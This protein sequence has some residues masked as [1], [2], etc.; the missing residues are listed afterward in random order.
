MNRTFRILLRKELLDIVRDKRMLAMMLM[1]PLVLY[2]ALF[3][4]TGTVMAAGK[5]RL[6]LQEL[7]VAVASDDAQAFLDLRPV[8]KHTTYARMTRA[9]GE[10]GLREKKIFAI[11]DAQP[12]SFAAVKAQAQGVVTIVYTKRQDRSV[13]ARDRV[14]AVIDDV[15]KG[16]LIARLEE[17]NLPATFSEPVK[18]KETDLDFEQNLGPYIASRLLPIMLLLMLF[19]GALY[20]AVDLTAGEKERG[21]LETL[22]VAPVQPLDVMK[23]KFVAV[24]A[25]SIIASVANLGAMGFAFASGVDLGAGKVTVSFSVPQILVMLSCLL[26]AAV[27]AAGI[28]LAIASLA[29]SFKEGQAMMTPVM[30]AALVPGMLAVMPGVELSAWTAC[31]PL[32]NVALLIKAVILQAAQ[33]VHVVITFVSVGLCA[34]GTLKL[35]ANAFHSEALRFGAVRSVKELFFKQ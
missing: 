27:L 24:A 6:A 14:R 12:G 3:V 2:P 11:V 15:S 8:P 26:P 16:T 29:R 18:R 4:I 31:I 20:P 34:L 30:L 35:A 7:T 32:L 13:E 33:P 19:L 9:E 17:A 22:L 21:T 25:T 5:A 23:A 28:S 10:A 1:V